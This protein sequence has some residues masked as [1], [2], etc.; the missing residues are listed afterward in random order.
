M[1]MVS[2]FEKSLLMTYIPSSARKQMPVAVSLTIRLTFNYL[3]K[4]IAVVVILPIKSRHL[5]VSPRTI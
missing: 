4:K 2:C 3:K 1:F 5:S